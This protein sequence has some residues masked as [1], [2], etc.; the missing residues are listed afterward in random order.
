[1]LEPVEP[2]LSRVVHRLDQPARHD[3]LP[4]L[5][6]DA[7]L[8]GLVAGSPTVPSC[9]GHDDALAQP[10]RPVDRAIAL[11][12]DEIGCQLVQHPAV[13]GTECALLGRAHRRD[14]VAGSARSRRR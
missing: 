9:A 8:R 7:A 2:G 5:G 12:D 6:E 14:L 10:A 4:V 13:R 1:M 3:Q 11:P